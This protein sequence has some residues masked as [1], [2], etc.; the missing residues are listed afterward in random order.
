MEFRILGPLEALEEGRAVGLGG[1]KQRALLAL[2]LVHANETLSVDRLIDELWGGRPPPTAAK[3]VRVY[4]SRLRRALAGG[5]GNGSGGV[6]ATRGRGYALSLDPERLDAHRFERLVAEGRGE[7]AAGDPGRAVATLEEALALWRGAPLA[8]LAYERFAQREAARLEELRIDALELLIDAKLALGRHGEV[9]G[10]LEALIAEHPYRERPRG[11]LMLA[12]YRS[13]RQAEALAAYQGARRTLV[14]ELGIE[15]GERLRE[16]ER[17]ILRQDPGLELPATEPAEREEPPGQLAPPSPAPKPV[18]RAVRKTVSVVFVGLLTSSERGEALDPEALRYVTGRA[19]GE[20]QTAIERH[21]GTVE[22][23]AGDAVTAVFG[24]PVVHEDD[25]LRAVRAATEMRERLASLAGKFQSERSVRFEFRIGVSTGK[26]VTGGETEPQLGATGE[27]MMVSSRLGQAGQRSDILLD[28]GTRRLVRDAVVVESTRVAS[29]SAF[30]LVELS[31]V[32]AG[33]PV[34][35]DSPMV[36]RER[37]RRRLHDAFAQAVG[38]RSCQ[39]FTVLGAAGVGKSRLVSEFLGEVANEALLARGRCLPYGEG[40]TYWPL[41]AA[42]REAVGL[43]DTDSSEASRAKLAAFVAGEDDAEPV[44]ERVAGVIGL[45]E[46]AGGAEEAFAAVRRL[47][48]TAARR[49]PLVLVFDDLQWGEATFLDLVEHIADWSREAPILLVCLARAELLDVRSGWAGGKLNATSIL[50]EPLSEQESSQLVENLAGGGL[51]ESARGRIVNAAEGNPLFVEEMLALVL[52]NGRRDAQLEV[53]PTIQALLAARLDRLRDEE[54]SAIEAA[55]VEGQV[56]HEAPL[57]ERLPE[58]LR[59]SV[60]EQLMALVRKELIRPERPEFRGERAFR[61]RHLLIR[62]A[63]YDS[64]P[65]EARAAFHER[66]AAWL[67]GKIGERGS[68]TVAEYEEILGYH[69]ERAF[70]YRAELGPVGDAERALARNAAERLA[71]AGRRAFVRSDAPAA[72]NLISRAVA[73]LPPDDPAR[74]DLVPTVRAAQGFGGELGWAVELLDEAIAAGD[75]RLRAHAL[76]Q[77]ALLRLFTGPDVSAEEL[78]GIAERAIAIFR[79]LGDEL[80]LAR[81]W[82]LL[83]QANY[84]ARRAGLS[85]EAAER[86]LMHSRRAADRFEERELAEWLGVTLVLGPMRAPEAARRC[87]RLLD[88]AA[89]DPILEA[90]A[91]AT[92]AVLV[93]LQGRIPEAQ[94]LVSRCRDVMEA[95]GEWVWLHSA[96]FAYFALAAGDPIAAERELRPGHER[97]RRGGEKS[98]FSSL[99]VLLAQAM[100]A[101]GRYKEAEELAAEASEAARPNDVH[102]QTIWRTVRAKALARRREPEAEELAREAI[103]F[104]EQSDFLPVHAE[105]LTDLAEVLRLAGQREEASRSLEASVRFHDQKGNVLAAA[106]ARAL[107]EDVR[108]Q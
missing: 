97:L 78:T 24:L 83:A 93:A 58:A 18:A 90:N 8:D 103:A 59:S 7:L 41:I 86:A 31:D 62:D 72:V 84:L 104:V 98:H 43:E 105:A 96:Y 16:L 73:L 13:G 88:E 60:H 23:V 30:R 9:I 44:C 100:C 106:R 69:L 10:R 12:L 102:V 1:S 4:V 56:F 2:F 54:R 79:E 71:A 3:T 55:S 108:Q 17:A 92:L 89:G 65:K 99:A 47:F 107:L 61:F 28:E 5:E 32:P 85:A 22:T 15:P 101:Q 77:R 95:S 49:R 87:E 14:E 57:A 36:G 74:V 52:E 33:H 82:R 21:G 51:E 39:L 6:L 29:L 20:V 53:P 40:I 45:A 76:V 25:A 70:R 34:R 91:L 66:H 35:L 42:V 68:R 50:L 26:V 63:A 80:G 27:P 11:Q 67:E 81:A 48:E 75:D 19:F 64:L 46:T 94:Q 37:E 38:D